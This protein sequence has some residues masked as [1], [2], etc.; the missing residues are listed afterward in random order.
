MIRESWCSF[1]LILGRVVTFKN[2]VFSNYSKMSTVKV[3]W[4]V[5]DEGNRH[6]TYNYK[7]LKKTKNTTEVKS[8]TI[9]VTKV[10]EVTYFVDTNTETQ[11]TYISSPTVGLLGTAFKGLSFLAV[12]PCLSFMSTYCSFFFEIPLELAHRIKIY[13]SIS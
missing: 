13:F 5:K 3:M 12:V 1:I 4:P 2:N 8:W 10:A 7:Q 11:N 6:L 9:W